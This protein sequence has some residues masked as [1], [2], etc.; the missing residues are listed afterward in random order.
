MKG[1]HIMSQWLIGMLC[2]LGMIIFFIVAS[3]II[4]FIRK[5]MEDIEAIKT[6]LEEH[7][8]TIVDIDHLTAQI[9]ERIVN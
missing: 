7:N 5:I 6:T 8:Q 4:D 2:G 3:I 1:I 9:Y